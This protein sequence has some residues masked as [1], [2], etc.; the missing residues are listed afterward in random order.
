MSDELEKISLDPMKFGSRNELSIALTELE[1]IEKLNG[2]ISENDFLSVSQKYLFPIDFLKK[3]LEG[4]SYPQ[5]LLIS[6]SKWFTVLFSWIVKEKERSLQLFRL[7]FA[8][9]RA[10]YFAIYIILFLI[11]MSIYADSTLQ[12]FL[13]ID[14]LQTLLGVI[15]PFALTIIS[16]IFGFWIYVNDKKTKVDEYSEQLKTDGLGYIVENNKKFIDHNVSR[17]VFAGNILLRKLEEA[18]A[19]TGFLVGTREQETKSGKK[20]EIPVY[21]GENPYVEYRK[22][23][24]ELSKESKKEQR[25]SEKEPKENGN[26]RAN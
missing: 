17:I 11:A 18:N 6:Q 12:L 3:G 24:E 4:F 26:D 2:H 21:Y 15:F 20:E 10:K 8:H 22:R 5:D 13:H 16:F 7:Q 23:I 19:I 14:L 9:V 25:K 1:S